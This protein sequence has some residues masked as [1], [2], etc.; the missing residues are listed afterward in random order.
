[1]QRTDKLSL[2]K[3]E[4]SQK[5]VVSEPQVWDEATQGRLVM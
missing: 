4:I 1:M 3:L 2:N 5:T